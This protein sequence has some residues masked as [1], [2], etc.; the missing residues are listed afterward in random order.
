MI[1]PEDVSR[2]YLADSTSHKSGVAFQVMPRPAGIWT[3]LFWG[4]VNTLV[5]GVLLVAVAALL[6]GFSR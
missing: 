2:Q 6:I 3:K 5:G 1:Y 4:G